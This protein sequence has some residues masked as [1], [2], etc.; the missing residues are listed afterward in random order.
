MAYLL[1]GKM[2]SLLWQIFDIVGLIFSVENGQK[3]KN[4]LTIWSHW[5]KGETEEQTDKWRVGRPEGWEREKEKMKQQ[6]LQVLNLGGQYKL[7]DRLG[8]VHLQY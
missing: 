6:Q 1:F 3:L 4:K 8:T 7:F 5:T 2:L